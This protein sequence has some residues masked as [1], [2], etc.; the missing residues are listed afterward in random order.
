MSLLL[1]LLAVFLGLL[2]IPEAAWVTLDSLQDGLDTEPESEQLERVAR[3]EREREATSSFIQRRQS[4]RRSRHKAHRARHKRQKHRAASREEGKTELRRTPEEENHNIKQHLA[5]QAPRRAPAPV[6]KPARA[7]TSRTRPAG[8]S[9]LQASEKEGPS[10]AED[11]DR[12]F[13]DSATL[14]KYHLSQSK[15]EEIVREQQA[16]GDPNM[17]PPEPSSSQMRA[18]TSSDRGFEVLKKAHEF[19]RPLRASSGNVVASL[20]AVADPE[21]CLMKLAY[22]T[23]RMDSQ[24]EDDY[25]YFPRKCGDGF[26]F[27]TGSLN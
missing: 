2:A 24:G 21:N 27:E 15:F 3:A 13:L 16:N 14:Q 4:A 10:K 20:M 8:G 5:P 1:Q 12:L 18:I 22:S 9:A 7:K 6:P 17:P 25:P 26:R 11:S 19:V 23:Y